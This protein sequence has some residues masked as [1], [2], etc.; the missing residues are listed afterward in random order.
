VE[1][2]GIACKDATF[3][4]DGRLFNLIGTLQELNMAPVV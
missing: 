4:V 3:V 1:G 2:T